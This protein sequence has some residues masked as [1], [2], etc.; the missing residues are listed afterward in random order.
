MPDP[1]DSLPVA[2]AGAGPAGLMLARHCATRGLPV[3]LIAP[4]PDRVWPNQYGM[5]V[6]EA[7]NGGVDQMLDPVWPR[8]EVIDRRGTVHDLARGYGRLDG[9]RLQAEWLRELRT[10]NVQLRDDAVTG[11]THDDTGCTLSLRSGDLRAALL[12][13]ATG[14]NSAL[15][16]RTGTATSFQT[17]WGITAEVSPAVPGLRDGVMRLMDFSTPWTARGELRV[18]AP[19]FLYAMPLADGRVFL[20]ETVLSGRPLVPPDALE[21]VLHA[22]LAAMGVNVRRVDHVERCVIPM[23]TPLP[24]MPQR[25]LAFG[26]AAAMVHPATGFMVAH[27]L[28]I[29]PRVA[30]AIADGR[31]RNLPPAACSARVWNAI[32]PRSERRAHDLLAFGGDVVTRLPGDLLGEFFSAFFALPDPLWHG[33]LSRTLPPWQLLRA[34]CRMYRWLGPD[35]RKRLRAEG[36]RSWPR[37]LRSLIGV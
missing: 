11:V 12:V 27:C 5:W 33:Y 23:N 10:A 9:A 31:R 8:A 29:A 14:H 6:D 16:E 37:L 20:E 18:P 24:A 7:A 19:T 21:P 15:V 30:D 35:L 34:M 13:D 28:R 2:I 17:A 32:W 1:A 25:T 4:Q 36:F 3:C 26:G 22:R